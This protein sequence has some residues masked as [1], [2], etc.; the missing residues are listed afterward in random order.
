MATI[1]PKTNCYH[2]R[3]KSTEERFWEKVDKIDNGCWLW[4]SSTVKDGYGSFRLNG[5]NVGAHRMAYF[6]KHGFWPNN[7]ACHS[8][9]TPNCVNPDHVWDGTDA[10]NSRDCLEK[11]R[12][13]FGEKSPSHKLCREIIST[14]RLNHTKGDRNFGSV[15]LAKILGLN[16]KTVSD[17]ISGKRWSHIK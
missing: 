2:Q 4:R 11:K 14:I 16:R 6:L 10:D 8:C 9:D 17:V 12:H 15:G 7:H 3:K 1:I 13:A 5:R